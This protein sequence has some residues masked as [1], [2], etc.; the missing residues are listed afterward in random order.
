MAHP[1]HE[2]KCRPREPLGDIGGLRDGINGV[3][4]TSVLSS[5]EGDPYHDRRVRARSR[6]TR[7][8]ELQRFRR[9]TI[10]NSSAEWRTG[11]V[12]RS[13]ALPALRASPSAVSL[14]TDPAARRRRGSA[15]RRDAGG[16][17]ERRALQRQI[18]CLDVDLRYCASQGSQGARPAGRAPAGLRSPTSTSPTGRG[19]ED[20]TMRGEIDRLVARG[21]EALV[22]RATRRRRAHLLP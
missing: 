3:E 15:R 10:G 21:L 20:A 9:K 8:F 11:I 18:P 7:C 5:G 1:A 13:N 22:A 16:V 2:R 17:A 6:R 14:Q 12:A 4:E 19:L